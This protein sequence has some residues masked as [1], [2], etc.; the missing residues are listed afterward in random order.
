MV[1]DTNSNQSVFTNSPKTNEKKQD[2]SFDSQLGSSGQDSR[3]VQEKTQKEIIANME[4]LVEDIDSVMRTGMTP[5][6][7]EQLEK[8]LERI[9]EEMNEKYPDEKKIKEMLDD[10]EKEIARFKKE[11]TGEAVIEADE[12]KKPSQA[13]EST[14][15]LNIE[16]RI[17]AAKKGIDELKEYVNGKQPTQLYSQS[18]LLQE[19]K[20]FQ[21]Q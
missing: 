14:V 21:N 17:D 6:E 11:I 4:K 19:I 3:Y 2:N 8:L 15:T 1:I 18:Q 5:E 10:L 20:Q 7:L 13:S 9:K 12:L 16:E